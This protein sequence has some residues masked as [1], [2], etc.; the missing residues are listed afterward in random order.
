MGRVSTLFN[1][2][3]GSSKTRNPMSQQLI[4]MAV[5]IPPDL[6]G[7]RLD[8]AAAALFPEFSRAQ[9]QQWIK[10]GELKV[11]GRCAKP[12]E[13]VLGG[14]SLLLETLCTAVGDWQP[15]NISLKVVHEDED[16]LIIDKPSGLVVHPGA[17]NPSGTLL[18]ALLHH[19][20]Q[21]Q[22]LPRAGIVHRLDKETSGLMVVARTPRGQHSLTAQLSA[23]SLTRIYEAVVQGNPK[24][25]GV[26]DKPIGR[27]PRVRTRMAVV[28]RGGKP[29]VTHFRIVHHYPHHAH[30]RI[31]LETGRTHQIRVHMADLGYPLVG[32][33]VYGGRLKVPP[34]ASPQ[35][36]ATLQGFRRQALHAT[37][38]SLVHPVSGETLSWSAPLQDDF[39]RLLAALEA[40]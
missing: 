8:Q 4:T 33:P 7:Q 28:E 18:N 23:R 40:G 9:L 5:E 30:L 13:R 32:D 19:Y 35:L 26:V 15:E 11:D 20:P 31:Q 38:L 21:Q 17:G 6:I 34:G 37:G 12:K 29:A 39:C 2:S 1:H 3:Q 10:V 22:N 14:E 27:H 24:A 36:V 16:F 25:G